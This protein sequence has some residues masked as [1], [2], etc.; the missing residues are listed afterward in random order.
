MRL[1]LNALRIGL[2]AAGVAGL[3]GLVPALA[4]S[5]ARA[6]LVIDLQGGQFQPMP[7]AVAE[8]AGEGNLGP[9]ISSIIAANLNRSGYFSPLDQSRFPERSPAFDAAPQ[10]DVWRQAGVQGLVTGRVTRD[11]QGRLRTEFRLWDV[12]SGQQI[13]GQ[14]YFTDPNN[15]RRVGHIISDAIF[16]RI[17][18]LAG[19]FDTRIVF[20]DETGPKENRLKRLAI[21]DQDG[22]NVRY[23]TPGD[24]SVVTPRFSPRAQ[25]IAFMAQVSG[26]QPRV[27]VLNLETGARQ[28]V[29]NFP[30]MTSSPRFSPNGSSIV[31]TLQQGGNANLYLIDLV[32]RTMTRLTSTLAI[33]TSPSFSP[34]GSQ[35]VF[36]SDRGGSQQLYT[37]AAD[38]SNPQRISF[39]QGTYSQPVWSP[40]GDWIAFTKMQ[41]GRFAIGVMR[42]DGSG[43]R[44]LTEGFHNE[45]PAWAPNGQYLVFFRDPG[46]QSGGQ[47]YMVDI[48]GRVEVPI[49]TPGYASDP[50][51]SPLLSD[52][53]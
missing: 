38:G 14:Q 33:D 34:D 5:P 40:R 9:Q 48:T 30:N 13:T 21:M 49:P 26:E 7:I 24:N 22:A 47:L 46:G 29:G 35:I 23:L 1:V 27:Q 42:P 8:F 19:F 25:E 37:M 31:M 18:G 53:R 36:E 51:W 11:G 15:W 3:A 32:S 17:T 43:E 10:F 28:A 39:G 4:P 41:G 44:I 45:S 12:Q 52:V 2:V 50:T 20:V 16:T 6:E